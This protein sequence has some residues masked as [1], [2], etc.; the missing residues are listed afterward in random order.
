[1]SLNALNE[2]FGIAQE[3]EDLVSIRDI[4]DEGTSRFI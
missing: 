2:V 1:M 4:E 3:Y